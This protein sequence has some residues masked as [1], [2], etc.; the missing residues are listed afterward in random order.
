MK[1][2]RIPKLF[3]LF[4]LVVALGVKFGIAQHDLVRGQRA[5]VE[6]SVVPVQ[7]AQ[8]AQ[9]AE[10]AQ[11]DTA[12]IPDTNEPVPDQ[13]GANVWGFIKANWVGLLFALGTFLEAIVRLTPTQRDDS[14]LN[15]LKNI[16]DSFIPNR[17]TGG[18]TH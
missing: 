17:R 10:I 8:V 5:Q 4:A 15:F 14:I 1:N 6:T 13:E 16:L 7:Y 9:V 11:A 12:D 3:A 18:G 2:Y